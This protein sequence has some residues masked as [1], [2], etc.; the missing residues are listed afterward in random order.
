MAL[1]HI[2]MDNGQFH[3]LLFY[4]L[5]GNDIGHCNTLGLLAEIKLDLLCFHALLP[6]T[7]FVFS[8]IVPRLI[9][10]MSP[11]LSY[12]EKICKRLNRMLIKFIP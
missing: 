10:L 12:P 11:E 8:E 9:W 2:C 7:I 6:D 5:S 4:I 3:E 1:Y